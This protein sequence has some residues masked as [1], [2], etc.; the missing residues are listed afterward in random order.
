MLVYTKFTDCACLFLSDWE[1]PLAVSPPTMTWITLTSGSGLGYWF[2]R[3]SDYFLCFPFSFSSQGGLSARVISSVPYRWASIS[4]FLGDSSPLC[5]AHNH[6]GTYN[7]DLCFVWYSNATL[8]HLSSI[9]FFFYAVEDFL[10]EGSWAGCKAAEEEERTLA[11][12]V[13]CWLILPL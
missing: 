7:I 12:M 6:R 11:L 3:P 13:V 8:R 5:L 10:S 1:V 4:P 2:L 9:A